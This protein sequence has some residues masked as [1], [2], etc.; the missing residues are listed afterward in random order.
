MSRIAA[1]S[2]RSYSE[3]KK[4]LSSRHNLCILALMEYGNMT[5]NEMAMC[6]YNEKKLP[7]FS[8]NFVHPRLTELVDLGMIKCDKTKID[9]ISYKKCKVY[10]LCLKNE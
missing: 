7:Y 8:R 5:A 2:I 10:E 1:T 4:T 9:T 3:V 6:L